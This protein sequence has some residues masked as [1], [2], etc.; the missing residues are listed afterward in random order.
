MGYAKVRREQGMPD[1]TMRVFLA[2]M[3]SGAYDGCFT[4]ELRKL[5]REQLAELTLMLR[6]RD[7]RDPQDLKRSG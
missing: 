2:N 3:D 7:R 4:A 6:E 1:L 5:S